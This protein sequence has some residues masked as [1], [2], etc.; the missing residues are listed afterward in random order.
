MIDKVVARLGQGAA[1]T[2]RRDAYFSI[3]GA[4]VINMARLTNDDE[5]GSNNSL[6]AFASQTVTL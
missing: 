2:L 4:Q 5:I 6:L 1:L 3:I